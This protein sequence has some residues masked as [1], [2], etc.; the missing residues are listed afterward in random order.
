[1]SEYDKSKFSEKRQIAARTHTVQCTMAEIEGE[2]K[3]RV[4]CAMSTWD[5]SDF[6]ASKKERDRA[7]DKRF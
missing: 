3:R 4:T 1:M 6:R 7:R 2:C 5:T